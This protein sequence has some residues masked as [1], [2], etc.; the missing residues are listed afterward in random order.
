MGIGKADT[1]SSLTDRSSLTRPDSWEIPHIED[2][3]VCSPSFNS[4]VS[5]P[6][7]AFAVLVGPQGLTTLSQLLGIPQTV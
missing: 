4:K 1:D 2:G 7:R 5:E 6:D 3:S